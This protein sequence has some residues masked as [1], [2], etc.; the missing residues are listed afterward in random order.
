MSYTL[1]FDGTTITG[2]TG[3]ASGHLDLS[4]T[5]ATA[6]GANAFTNASGFTSL[7]LPS[8]LTTIGINAF[9]G[10][11]GFT[12]SLVIP[13]NVT[14]ISAEAFKGCT[15][16]TGSLTL[17]S[18]LT[19]IGNG[20]FYDCTGFTGNLVIPNSVTTISGQAFEGCTGFTGSLTLSSSL[21][22][23]GAN[24]FLGCG[25]TGTLTVPGSVISIG[26]DAFNW[27]T[28]LTS[29]VLTSATSLTTLGN[30]VFASCTGLTGSLTLPASLTS[31]GTGVFNSTGYTS[32]TF[33][34]NSYPPT[35]VVFN[36]IAWTSERTWSTPYEGGGG[37][38]GG[39][40]PIC[41]LGSAPVLTPTGYRRMDSLRAGDLVRT[42]DGRSVAIQRVKTMTAQPGPA[43]DPFVIPAGRFG[44]TAAL[45]ISPR[46]RVAVPGR[47]MVEARDIG[48]L[49]RLPMRAA[50]TYYNIGLP[51]WEADNLVVGGVEVESLAPVER[52]RMTMAEFVAILTKKYGAE[53]SSKAVLDRV[54]A[55]CRLGADGLVEA[56]VIRKAR[57][58]A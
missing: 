20:A 30:Q 18:S 3:T 36:N 22:T 49:A 6:I 10:C 8:G 4:G 50:W 46:H 29:L 40:G 19:T 31:I 52:V 5:G 23:I 26:G 28:G 45:P 37:G 55:T 39:G 25:F 57:K 2:F 56:P 38:G 44:A 32:F 21:T 11:T 58:T 1:V 15:G 42:A 9:F 7:T 43:A 33:L 53:A 24:A 27:C 35:N 54:L 13:N 14:T 48:G 51:N 41:F 17:S 12:G 47:G 34:N 16:F